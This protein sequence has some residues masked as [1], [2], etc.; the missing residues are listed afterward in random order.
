VPLLADCFALEWK[1]DGL[2]GTRTV[3]GGKVHAK[4]VTAKSEAGYMAT[5]RGGAFPE[6]EHGSVG[7]EV[8]N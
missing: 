6:A 3:Y 1:D 4:V 7:G 8:K 5:I 2:A